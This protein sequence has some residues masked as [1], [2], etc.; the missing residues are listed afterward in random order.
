MAGKKKRIIKTDEPYLV[1][2]GMAMKRQKR[3]TDKQLQRIIGIVCLSFLLGTAG[4]ALLANLLPQGQQGQL[5]SF[6]QQALADGDEI[7]FA[8]IFWKY[9]K[10][11]IIIWLGGWMQLGLFFAGAAFLFRSVCVGFTSAMMMA[12]Y[13]MKGVL[14]SA[15]AFLPQNLLL[16]PCYILMMSACVYYLLSWQEEGGKRTLQREKRRKQLEYCIL[17]GGSVLLLA[18]ASGVERMLL[19]L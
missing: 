5:S 18:A 13:G 16:I 6:L 10:Y 17:F 3:R 12:A 14:L 2:G 19:L 4:G 1:S 9:L 11:D 7:S 8:A 15:T